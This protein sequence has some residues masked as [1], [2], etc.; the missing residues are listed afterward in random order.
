MRTGFERDV[1]GRTLGPLARRL[2][3]QDFRMRLAGPGMEALADHFIA[4]RD[5]AADHGI[6]P[7]GIGAAFGEPQRAGHHQMIGGTEHACL[8]FVYSAT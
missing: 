8:S 6:G 2:Q 3:R 5:H 4:L 1:D 7:G